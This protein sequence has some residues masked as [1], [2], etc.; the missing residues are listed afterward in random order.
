M[1]NSRVSVLFAARRFGEHLIERVAIRAFF[2]RQA[3]VRAEDA[4]LPQDA[5]VRRIDVLVRR[6]RDAVAVLRAVHR[7]GQWPRPRR[8]GVSKSATPSAGDEPLAAL[9]LVGDR[10]RAPDR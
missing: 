2:L 8:S 3:R 9:D 5:D 6:E 1:W 10:A 4:G 7:V